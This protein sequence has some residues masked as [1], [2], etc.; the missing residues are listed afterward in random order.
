MLTGTKKVATS[1]DLLL[2]DLKSISKSLKITINDLLTACLASAI[3]QYFI[4][5]GDIKNNKINIVIPA[6]IRF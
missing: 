5:K 3:K 4:S 1:S 2:N 6:N